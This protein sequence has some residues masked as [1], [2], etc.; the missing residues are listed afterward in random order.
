MAMKMPP[1]V[2]EDQQMANS[3]MRDFNNPPSTAEKFVRFFY[4]NSPLDRMNN[5][6]LGVGAILPSAL[7]A[8]GLKNFTLRSSEYPSQWRRLMKGERA[9]A[10]KGVSGTPEA[11]MG[12]IDKQGPGSGLYDP[13]KNRMVYVDEQHAH[14]AALDHYNRLNPKERMEWDNI[15][16]FRHTPKETIARKD[17]TY[18]WGGDFD[19]TFPEGTLNRFEKMRK[20][21]DESYSLMYRM[22][23]RLGMLH[24]NLREPGA[25]TW[26]I[27]PKQKSLPSVDPNEWMLK[28][29]GE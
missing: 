7:N 6:A 2:S 5:A 21:E 16:R 11:L 10:V 13:I 4:G 15:S 26:R 8:P 27:A 25:E 1:Q 20:K 14:Q 23:K 24:D 29:F 9:P 3:V 18:I 19:K 28:E 12:H 22:L 17:R